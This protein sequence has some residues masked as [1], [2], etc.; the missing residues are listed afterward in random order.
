[1]LEMMIYNH[2]RSYNMV[3]Q[4]L[5]LMIN[6]YNTEF[7]EVLNYLVRLQNSKLISYLKIN[8]YENPMRLGTELANYDHSNIQTDTRFII[9]YNRRYNVFV[10]NP[11][12]TENWRN[13]YFTVP[14]PQPEAESDGRKLKTDEVRTGLK[15][16]ALHYNDDDFPYYEKKNDKFYASEAVMAVGESKPRNFIVEETTDGDEV[17]VKSEDV[18]NVVVDGKEVDNFL[19]V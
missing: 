15:T 17:V 13:T 3:K 9:D 19:G 2:L 1:M 18:K 11:N 8:N 16:M 4:V 6:D 12:I 7:F 10:N 5:G 14:P